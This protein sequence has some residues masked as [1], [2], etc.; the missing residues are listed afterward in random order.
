LVVIQCRWHGAVVIRPV[1]MPRTS[2]AVAES[3][4]SDHTDQKTTHRHTVR[5][6]R[7][8]VVIQCR[9]HGAVV[10]RPVQMPRT[11]VAVAVSQSSRLEM[12]CSCPCHADQSRTHLST[13]THVHQ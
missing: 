8:Q 11:S 12:T 2:V 10:V 6:T 1:Q 4:S 3:Q 7:R 13:Q 5:H 9:W